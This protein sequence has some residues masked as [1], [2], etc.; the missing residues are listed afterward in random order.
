M[1]SCFKVK[2]TIVSNCLKADPSHWLLIAVE[3]GASVSPHPQNMAAGGLLTPQWMATPSVHMAVQLG[4]K[5]LSI[6]TE[7]RTG[8]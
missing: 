7:R 2:A 8:T 5:G 6:T 4:L 1:R 3:E